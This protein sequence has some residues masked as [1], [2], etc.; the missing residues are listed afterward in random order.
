MFI[1]YISLL[2]LYFRN[3][4]E[5]LLY[6]ILNG[7]SNLDIPNTDIYDKS[8]CC[9]SWFIYVYFHTK[10]RMYIVLGMSFNELI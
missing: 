2:S 9:K 1:I 4:N 7:L 8:T 6:P 10:V 5:K 3:A